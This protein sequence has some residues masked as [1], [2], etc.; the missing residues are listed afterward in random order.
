MEKSN[1]RHGQLP[2]G[3]ALQIEWW[4]SWGRFG[5]F[6]CLAEASMSTPC[7]CGRQRKDVT[8]CREINGHGRRSWLEELFD[9]STDPED[10]CQLCQETLDE[11]CTPRSH[12]CTM[13]YLST[14]RHR[15]TSHTCVHRYR[16][17]CCGKHFT[18]NF[19]HWLG[20][21][22]HYASCAEGSSNVDSSS[23]NTHIF[24]E[25][26]AVPRGRHPG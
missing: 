21:L 6:G 22:W 20:H 13:S 26:L 16:W 5:A 23:G 1:N 15:R 9:S 18:G 3:E 4:Q 25:G 11:N 24:L 8:H 2:S 17:K 14:H 7:L 10:T 19:I 12:T